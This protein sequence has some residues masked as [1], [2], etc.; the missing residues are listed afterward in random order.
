MLQRVKVLC[1]GLATGV[2]L[3]ISVAPGGIAQAARSAESAALSNA[4]QA[5]VQKISSYFNKM[6]SLKGEFTQIS[7]KGRVSSGIFYIAKPGRLRFEYAAPNPFIIVSD[8]Q[9]LVI[10]NKKKNRA[11]QYPLSATPLRLVLADRVDLL[12]QAIIRKV[13]QV[14]DLTTVTLE[15]RDQIVPGHLILVYNNSQSELQQ[16]VVVDGQGR[17]TTISLSKIEAGV[18]T[19]PKLFKVKLPDTRKPKSDR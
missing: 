14:D 6:R 5:A 13:E 8:G 18:K 12:K 7:P 15:D 2:L 10:K 16:W 19:D 17:R 11:D 3:A 4:Q 9:W 1:A